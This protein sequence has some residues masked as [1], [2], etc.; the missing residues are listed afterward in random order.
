MAEFNRAKGVENNR[1]QFSLRRINPPIYLYNTAGESRAISPL[2]HP[3]VRMWR[4][5]CKSHP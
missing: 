1:P 5:R 4:E 3:L 2:M